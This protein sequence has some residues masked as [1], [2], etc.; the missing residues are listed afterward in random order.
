MKYH[1]IVKPEAEIDILESAKWYELKQKELGTRFI[2]AID[3]KIAL[4]AKN[5]LKYQKRYK[6]VRFALLQKFPFAIH[7]II[8]DN[9]IYVLAVLSTQHNPQIWKRE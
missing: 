3:E 8:D 4:I 2:N 7:F 5:P 6:E 9:C 1:L